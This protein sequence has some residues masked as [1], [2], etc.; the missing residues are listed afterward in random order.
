MRHV[1]ASATSRLLSLGN[2][3]TSASIACLMLGS[4][5]QAHP[6]SPAA[7]IEA[8]GLELMTVGRVTTL[9]APDD[10]ARA[11]QLAALSEAAAGV[12]ERE[13]GGRSSFGW[14]FSDQRF[15]SRRTAAQV[16]RTASPGVPWPTG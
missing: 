1:E 3:V 11:R 16:C 13:L 2:L 15:G 6:Q 9:F 10:R 12:F 7:R 8:L 4:L 5:V 14:R